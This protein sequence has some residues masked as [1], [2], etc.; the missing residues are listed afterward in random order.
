[1]SAS[2]VI[3]LFHFGLGSVQYFFFFLSYRQ[4]AEMW[5]ATVSAWHECLDVNEC[6]LPALAPSR[7]T[8]AHIIWQRESVSHTH[9]VHSSMTVVSSSTQQRSTKTS[10]PPFSPEL[11]TAQV[12]AHDPVIALLIRRS[13]TNPRAVSCR[14]FQTHKHE[15]MSADRR[16]MALGLLKHTQCSVVQSHGKGLP[17][18]LFGKG[19]HLRS[20]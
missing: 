16:L 15:L 10:P 12:R 5:N 6:R 2:I 3:K 1:M 7:H 20:H 4:C 18:C 14:F 17:Y 9:S 11:Q 13:E 8:I 19:G